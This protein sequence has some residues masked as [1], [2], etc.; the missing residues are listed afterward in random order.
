M[1]GHRCSW[2][3]YT[4]MSDQVPTLMEWLTPWLQKLAV[5]RQ[6][7]ALGS[8]GWIQPQ[9]CFCI[10]SKVVYSSFRA[11]VLT[12]ACMVVRQQD[13]IYLLATLSVL[14]CLEFLNVICHP[15]QALGPCTL[16][17][18]FRDCTV[19][20]HDFFHEQQIKS[21]LIGRALALRMRSLNY[22]WV[23]PIAYQFGVCQ[24][25]VML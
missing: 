18:P 19:C 17:V 12:Q 14:N 23:F 15:I 6:G 4:Q 10:H 7:C 22:Y 16:S 2:S 24:N 3:I 9:G 20:Y 1:L 8:L 11:M 25:L 21:N 13:N 5:G